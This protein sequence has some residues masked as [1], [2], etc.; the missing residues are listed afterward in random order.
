MSMKTPQKELQ[1][2][3]SLSAKHT[4]FII[5]VLKMRKLNSFSEDSWLP[6]Y[7]DLAA[8]EQEATVLQDLGKRRADTGQSSPCFEFCLFSVF[9]L[10]FIVSLFPLLISIFCSCFGLF[11]QVQC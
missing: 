6:D 8:L 9:M 5:I 1:L 3:I 2:L 4:V 10:Y 11:T 7:L